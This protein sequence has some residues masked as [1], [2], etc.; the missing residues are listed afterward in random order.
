[1]Q[2]GRRRLRETWT[3]KGTAGPTNFQFKKVPE[4]KHVWR[5]RHST[6]GWQHE[7]ISWGSE[8]LLNETTGWIKKF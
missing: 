6:I 7:K 5:R 8:R 3:P 4:F 1:M 2:R